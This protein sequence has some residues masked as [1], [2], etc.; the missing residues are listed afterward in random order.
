MKYS[1][2]SMEVEAMQFTDDNKDRVFHTVT[3]IQNNIQA[4]W[5]SNKQPCLLIP[6][7]EGEIECN[8][9]DYLIIDPFPTDWNKIFPY[10][11]EIFEKC[12]LQLLMILMKFDVQQYI[13]IL[14]INIMQLCLYHIQKILMLIH[15]S[16]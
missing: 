6:T 8:L 11:K 7:L 5:N 3:A 15:V 2:K 10:R 1:T 4:S 12:I 13:N 9:G 14:K 16:I